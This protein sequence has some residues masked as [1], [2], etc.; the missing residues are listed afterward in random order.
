MGLF[1]S[2]L[3]QIDGHPVELQ[4]KR[5]YCDLARWRLG[6]VVAGA[7]AGIRVFFDRLRL[8]AAYR[9]EYSD[10]AEASPCTVFVVLVHSVFTACEVVHGDLDPTAIQQR[11][12]TLQTTWRDTARV[13]T[14]WAEFLGQRQDEAARQQWRIDHALSLIDHARR[15]RGA[16]D[17][18]GFLQAL[19]SEEEKC[20]ES[21]EDVLDVLRSALVTDFSR[22]FD[23]SAAVFADILDEFRL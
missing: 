5:F 13:M 16:G 7:P 23:S 22:P 21:G 11:I 9:V 20:L 4:T 8:D 12:E 6:D 14:T 10:T 3:I 2:F 19:R 18:H 1:D 17:A 15:P